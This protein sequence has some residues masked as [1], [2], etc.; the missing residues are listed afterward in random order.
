MPFTRMLN[1]VG[2]LSETISL[3]LNPISFKII[4]IKLFYIVTEYT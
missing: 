3:S 1:N 2:L 4:L